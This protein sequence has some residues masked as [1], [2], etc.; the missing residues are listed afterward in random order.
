MP[1]SV[2]VF[3][4]EKAKDIN[5]LFLNEN[6]SLTELFHRVYMIDIDKQRLNFLVKVHPKT[7]YA[8]REISRLKKLQSIN[9]VP[10]IL[11]SAVSPG[12]N[13]IVMS[14]APGVDLYE[15]VN[16]YGGLIEDEVQ[17]IMRKLLKII[18]SVHKKGVIHCDIKPE[19]IIYDDKSGK[20][21][22]IDFEGK[23][24]EDYRSPEQ[25]KGDHL[26]SKTDMWSIGVTCYFIA[27]GNTPYNSDKE[28]LR[29]KVK[30]SKR[31]SED[32]KDFMS[33]LMERDIDH[34]YS[35]REALNHIWLS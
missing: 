10:K 28:I 14:R 6:C 35:A 22:L 9:G 32:F 24:T 12:I 34:R 3:I 33:C 2:V 21:T 23:E 26:T 15:Y 16:R 29:K 31:W 7:K 18:K 4:N 5:Q 17:D 1:D 20:V 13:Y 8:K 25:I 30:F 27:R 11:T 19:N